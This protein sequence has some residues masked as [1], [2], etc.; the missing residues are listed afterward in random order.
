MSSS[1]KSIV[2]VSRPLPPGTLRKRSAEEREGL[3]ARFA[4]S[5]QTQARFCRE[6]HLSLSTLTYWLR[7]ER[8]RVPRP[9]DGQLVQLPRSVAGMCMAAPGEPTAGTVQ[10]RLPSQIELRVGVG[11]DPA[12]VGALLQG[13]LACSA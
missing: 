6:N 2:P 7:Q 9:V 1:P 5:G 11:A 10:I 4:R 3:L 13:V 12:W 8:Q